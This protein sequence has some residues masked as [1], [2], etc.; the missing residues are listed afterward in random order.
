MQ[1]AHLE[2]LSPSQIALLKG[3]AF[4]RRRGRVQLPSGARV[5]SRDLS[6]TLVTVAFLACAS[7]GVLDLEMRPLQ[8]LFGLHIGNALFVKPQ[9]MPVPWATSS[10]EAWLTHLAIQL[11]GEERN[12]VRT[13]VYIL[14]REHSPDPWRRVV[15][16]VQG[17]LVAMGI[18][19]RAEEQRF[20]VARQHRIPLCPPVVDWVAH[21]PTEHVRELLDTCR[22]TDPQLWRVLRK[23]IS[24]GISYRRKVQEPSRQRTIEEEWD[25]SFSR[26]VIGE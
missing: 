7:Q 13:L 19:E 16:E 12:R 21:L 9:E 24:L 6:E 15:A 18:V 8:G 1:Q 5:S 3:E 11:R 22:A 23:E 20:H 14:L 2:R 17:G 4:V 26:L 10:L 25:E